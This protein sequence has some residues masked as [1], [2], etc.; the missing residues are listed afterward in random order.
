MGDSALAAPQTD[1]KA[2]D[3][4]QQ[5][6]SP[7]FLVTV[8]VNPTQAPRLIHG[9]NDYKLYAALRGSDVKIDTK[10]QVNDVNIFGSVVP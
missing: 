8:A 7:S 3:Q 1:A 5:A 4:Q 10:S 9:I 6:K 2:G